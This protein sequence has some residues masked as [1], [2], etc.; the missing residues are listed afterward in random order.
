[1]LGREARVAFITLPGVIEDGSIVSETFCKDFRFYCY[2]KRTFNIGREYYPLNIYGGKNPEDPYHFAPDIGQLVGKDGTL[3]ALRK[4]PARWA[5]LDM[6]RAR[7][8]RP[9]RMYD[10]IIRGTP[11]AEVVNVEVYH[12][13]DQRQTN[14]PSETA[15][16]I[17]RYDSAKRR[18]NS[19]LIEL[20]RRLEKDHSGHAPLSPELRN[21]IKRA[22]NY[23]CLLYTS[24]SPRD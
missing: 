2:E 13:G 23:N 17:E 20:Y 18:R 3:V 22:L 16:W 5:S 9:N 15:T 19:R 6:T 21:E 12:D 24:P 1:M 11:G 7:M 14:L 8:R 4:R 10:R